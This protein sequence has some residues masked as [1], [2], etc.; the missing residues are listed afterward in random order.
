MKKQLIITMLVLGISLSG[1][2]K[3]LTEL[4]QDTVAP[5][6]FFKTKAQLTAALMSVYSPLGA[7]DE[8]TYSRFFVLEGQ[9]TDEFTPTSAPST[10]VDATLYNTSSTYPK[11]EAAWNNLYLGIERANLLLEN[12]DKATATAEDVSQIKGEALFL[13]AYYHFILVSY[14]GDIPL[15]LITTKKASDVARARTP[16]K[17]VYDKV[18]ADMTEAESLVKTSTSWGVNN[19][20]R[21]SKTGVEGILSRVCLHAAGRLKDKNYLP[22]AVLWGKKVIAS[23]EHK[24]NPDFKRIFINESQDIDDNSEC[25]WEVQFTRDATGIYNEYERFGSSIGIRNDD[26]VN[27]GFMQGGYLTSGTFYETYADGDLRRDW[28]IANYTYAV[29]GGTRSPINGN[30]YTKTT[31][32]WSRTL[33]KWRREY[34]SPAQIV[35]KNF[36]PTN[37]P[38]LRYADVLLTV[39]EAQNEI[40]GPTT[41]SIEYVNQVRRRG[42]GV[43]LVG[44]NIKKLTITSGGT[45]GYTIGSVVTISGGG[46]SKDAKAAITTVSS[47]KITDI[48]I[49]DGGAGYTSNPIITISGGSGANITATLSSLSDCELVASNYASKDAFR[50]FIM[51][52]RSRELAGESH[53]KLDLFRWGNFVSTM[54][55]IIPAVTIGFKTILPVYV[56]VTDRDVTYPIPLQEMNLNPL[57]TQNTGW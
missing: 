8:S 6:T 32:H 36:G 1:C 45:S 4:P 35:I 34:Q 12:L 5:E 26:I 33:A 17:E 2:E 37:L 41:E 44:R 15:K 9:A 48:S 39:A 55:D 3:F 40:N 52:E 24:L 30:V 53:H 46:A 57:M 31:S 56:N 29:V 28:T 25:I 19:T 38:L 50:T 22:A 18:I 54:K 51:Q 20:A 10:R 21:I 27:G 43:S 7:T 49:I 11:F 42:Y 16:A 14:W 23:N 47:G 13:R